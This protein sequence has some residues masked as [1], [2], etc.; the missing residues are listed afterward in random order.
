M[1]KVFATLVAALSAFSCTT[2][3]EPVR[4]GALYS[5][6]GGEGYFQVAKVLVTDAT[7][8]HIRLYRN[9]FETR[10]KDVDLL[11]LQ[12][13]S[14]HDRD[15]LGMGHVPLTHRTFEAWQPVYLADSSVT[16]DELEGYRE[17]ESAKGG[18]FGLQ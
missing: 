9:R 8:V 13:G 5:V 11:S 16:E 12:L 17:W 15:E 2:K 1:W 10:P 18:Y 3:A 7:G 4:A 14:I 6:N